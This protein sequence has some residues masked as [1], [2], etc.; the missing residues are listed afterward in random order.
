MTRDSP[1]SAESIFQN[2]LDRSEAQRRAY[3][4]HAC[5]ADTQLLAQVTVLL[6][7]F[8]RAGTSFH[9][10]RGAG[11]AAPEV[12]GYTVGALL[13]EG[14]M[15]RVFEAQQHGPLE[16]RVALKVM[17]VGLA[18]SAVPR[19][20]AERRALS[21]ITHPYVAQVLD[22]GTT[23]T[24]EP[25]FTMEYAPGLPLPEYC[26]EHEL[27]LSA[28]LDVFARV[29]SGVQHAHEQ[30]IFH[31][32]LKPSNVLVM[33]FSGEAVPKIIDFGVAKLLDD[34]TITLASD[35]IV[36][37]T[38]EYMSP[39]QTKLIQ[40]PVDHRSDIYSLGMLLYELLV[41]A[42]PWDDS[43]RSRSWVEQLRI[44]SSSPTTPPSAHEVDPAMA[45]RRQTDP[46][47]LRR[48]L[49]GPLDRIFLRATNHDLDRRYASVSELR[50]DILE[51]LASPPQASW[52]DRLR[53]LF[54]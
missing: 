48:A 13:G 5:G 41:G 47:Q 54:R 12:E 30:G 42:L 27:P 8:D 39:E 52:R 22:A 14:G 53:E 21:R 26:D 4:E 9:E 11:W 6:D 31:R 36:L 16:R 15:G 44:V 45:A 18:P 19:F 38:P 46:A 40:A 51:F 24:G 50:N 2:A 28:R 25:F 17:L 43:F 7:H 32:D 49:S 3:V 1:Q 34:E 33:N 37:G 29:C 23:S 35:F 10:P 20:Q